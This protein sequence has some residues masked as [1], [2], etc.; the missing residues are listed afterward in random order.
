[1]IENVFNFDNVSRPIFPRGKLTSAVVATLASCA[2]PFCLPILRYQTSVKI[3][4]WT[5]F[6]V[7][8][9]GLERAG[10]WGRGRAESARG[11][12]NFKTINDIEMNLAA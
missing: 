7:G 9:L 1:M 3:C 2:S 8:C 4:F 5:L 10:R 6:C 11:L 12:V